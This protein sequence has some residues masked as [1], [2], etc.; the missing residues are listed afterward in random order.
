MIPLPSGVSSKSIA[1]CNLTFSA[2]VCCCFLWQKEGDFAWFA[3]QLILILIPGWKHKN[4]VFTFPKKYIFVIHIE[5]KK[6][7][8]DFSFSAL[9]LVLILLRRGE[10]YNVENK[11]IY[12]HFSWYGST[13]LLFMAD[14]CVQGRVKASSSS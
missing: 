4:H 11:K 14:L 10:V 5:N 6:D 7:F 13:T 1:E 2:N 12:Q 8:Y 3:P 9:I